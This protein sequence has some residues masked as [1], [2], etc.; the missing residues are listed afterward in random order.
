M[1]IHKSTYL[2][3]DRR[4][5]ALCSPVNS[6]GHIII[7]CVDNVSCGG[8]V[9]LLS[10]LQISIGKFEDSQVAKSIQLRCVGFQTLRVP[11]VLPQHKTSICLKDQFSEDHFT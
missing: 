10:S 3:L 4:Y 8:T 1:Y 2:V 5:T 6:R 7:I 11:P 9:F